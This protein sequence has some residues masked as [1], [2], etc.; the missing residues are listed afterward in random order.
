MACAYASAQPECLPV[1]LHHGWCLRLSLFMCPSPLI[2][3]AT[4][5]RVSQANQERDPLKIKDLQAKWLN[6]QT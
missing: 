4:G 1:E 5:V 3:H 6:L 2:F